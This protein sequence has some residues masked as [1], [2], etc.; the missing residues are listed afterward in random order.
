MH[1]ATQRRVLFSPA[2]FPVLLV[3]SLAVAEASQEQL[4][5]LVKLSSK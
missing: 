4:M 1:S 2:L 5:P 3:D